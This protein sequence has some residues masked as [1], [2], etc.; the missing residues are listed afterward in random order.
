[1]KYID[2]IQFALKFDNYHLKAKKTHS[3]DNRNVWMVPGIIFLNNNLKF[4]IIKRK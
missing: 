3:L 2:R 1:M 4:E